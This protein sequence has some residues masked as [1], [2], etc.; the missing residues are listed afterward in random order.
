MKSTELS[1]FPQIIYFYHLSCLHFK[2]HINSKFVIF[3]ESFT[4][5]YGSV[6]RDS[7]AHP[8]IIL[9]LDE[10]VNIFWCSEYSSFTLVST[11]LFHWFTLSV[12]LSGSTLFS[13]SIFLEMS[14]WQIF[15]YSSEIF[16]QDALRND[17]LL[18]SKLRLIL[19][20]LSAIDWYNIFLY[21]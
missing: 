20:N 15:V 16:T 8:F 3:W 2:N 4:Q 6:V 17:T 21:T 10:S 7:N 5:T 18:S 13:I 19:I 14:A 12:P 9:C 1:I 11:S